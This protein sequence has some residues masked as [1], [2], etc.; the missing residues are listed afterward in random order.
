MGSPH[1]KLLTKAHAL[2]RSGKGPEALV[3]YETFL[4]LEPRQAQAWAD[5]AG[6][7][8]V[9]HKLEEA[10][11]ACDRSLHID[12]RNMAAKV[13]RACISIQQQQWGAS[14]QQLREVLAADSSQ[15]SARLAMVLCLINQGHPGAAERE[16]A[17]AIQ[18]EPGRIEAHQHLGSI[19]YS[20][21]RWLEFRREI[22][23]YRQINPSS[24]YLDFEQG[25]L[26]LLFGEMPR[27]WDGYEARWK[28]PGLI[29]PA[30][31]FSEPSW[32]GEMFP[33]KTLLLF[34]EQGFG[35]TLMF[36]RYASMAKAR[37]GRVILEVQPS[38]VDL[39]AT[40]P[41]IDEVMAH[42]SPLPPFDLQLPLLS[43]P[44]IFQTDLDSI[45][46]AVP[47]L[48]IPENIP[49]KR[50]ISEHMALAIA[51]RK[52][53]IGLVW[54]GNPTH[55]RDRERSVP[56]ATLAPLA[57]LPE[58]AWFSFQME[59]QEPPS[60]PNLISLAPHLS[61]FADTAYALSGMDLVITVDTALAHVAGA[62]GIPTLLLLTFQ[63]DWRW[64]L[65]RTD[66]PWYPS[67]HLYRQPEPGD[68][69]AVIQHVLADL[70]VS[71]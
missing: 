25:F 10:Q 36:I 31:N 24:A 39:V 18:Q 1:W 35:D 47:Y 50:A 61:N 56:A 27:G 11:K 44:Q 12:P 65:A 38:L 8:L 57:I 2:D 60:L 34:Y 28:L 62:L 5:Y 6:Q 37:G 51:H 55:K 13:N 16:L 20:Q 23:R 45:P 40:C 71:D 29:T 67:L 63:P 9:L 42:G 21:G 32:T 41:G 14:E 22:D 54:A 43:L 26:D 58:V 52:T 48:D 15:L 66:S 19:L 46:D 30:R 33:G 64:M 3:A 7:L 70:S 59:N 4:A 68:W 17:L 53:R 49:G 69:A